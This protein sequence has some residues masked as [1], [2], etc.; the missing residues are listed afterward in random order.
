MTIHAADHMLPVDPYRELTRKVWRTHTLGEMCA[1]T[2]LSHTTIR[3]VMFGPSRSVQVR[4][5]VR[6]QS[7]RSLLPED[8][9]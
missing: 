4:T 6:L 1:A 8:G 2:G 3:K 9:A 5:A 7:L